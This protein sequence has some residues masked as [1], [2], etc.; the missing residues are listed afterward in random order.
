M[1]TR[2]GVRSGSLAPGGFGRTTRHL[3][4]HGDWLGKASPGC[5][6]YPEPDQGPARVDHRRARHQVQAQPGRSSPAIR[7]QVR[8]TDD[9]QRTAEGGTGGLRE[10]IG[11]IAAEP[12]RPSALEV[13]PDLLLS[14]LLD[15]FGALGGVDLP[16]PERQEPARGADL[17]G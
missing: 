6:H 1:R 3:L 13:I 12:G 2:A 11:P 17:G 9:P 15:T 7:Q 4:T 5:G 14:T 10:T 16:L 8:V